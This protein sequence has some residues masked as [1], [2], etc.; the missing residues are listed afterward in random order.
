MWELCP[1][2]CEGEVGVF[3]YECH[4]EL[5]HNPVLLR[6]DIQRFAELVR[7]RGLSEDVKTEGRSQIAGR[8][9]LLHEVIASGISAVLA[10]DLGD[11]G[12]SRLARGNAD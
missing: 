10:E 8:I 7:L 3:C 2:N 4:E 1:W 11:A 5:I 12:P 6:E 9:R